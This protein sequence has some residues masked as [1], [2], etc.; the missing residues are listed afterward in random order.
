MCSCGSFEAVLLNLGGGTGDLDWRRLQR[1]GLW[2]SNFA[3][4]RVLNLIALAVLSGGL[5]VVVLLVTWR[6]PPAS[7]AGRKRTESRCVW[8]RLGAELSE[9]EIRASLVADGHGLSE[10]A[11]GPETV[12]DDSVNDDAERFNNDFYDAADERPILDC[13]V[14]RE[15]VGKRHGITHLKAAHETVGHVVLEQVSSWIFY[16]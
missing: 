16:A 8:C 7:R 11:L 6:W 2:L 1:E 15:K 12:K 13:I 3:S 9:V 5:R 4:V 10:L 14:S